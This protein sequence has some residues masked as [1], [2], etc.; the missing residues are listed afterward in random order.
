MSYPPPLFIL[1]SPRSFTSI[2]CAV[3]GQHPQAYGT[4]ELNL[5]VEDRVQE[6]WARLSGRRQFMIHGVLRMV[7]QLYAGEQDAL[8]IDMARRW[9]LRRLASTT[10]E[11]Y[12]ELCEKISPLLIIDKSPVYPTSPRN[13][14]RINAA[15]PD[16]HYLHLVRH[17]RSQGESVMKLSNGMFA[18]MADSFDY[19]TLP[20]T[21]DPQISWLSIQQNIARFLERI[22]PE[23]QMRMRGEDFLNN[24]DENLRICCEW[25]GLSV[26]PASTEAMRHPETSP[27][28]VEGP[29]GA[30]LGNDINFLRSPH[31]RHTTIAEAPLAG[32]LPW[33]PDG[34]GLKQEVLELAR[35]YGYQ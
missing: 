23:Q 29:F 24:L 27:Y 17:P 7:A 12:R 21:L 28:A 20:P 31:L 19:D 32:S 3:L 25:L 35:S 14:N 10:A 33:R 11:V 15:F 9:L 34:R 16:A 1:G 18:V 8:T 30:R 13:L 5:F 22:P 26:D 2:V 4:P 6:L